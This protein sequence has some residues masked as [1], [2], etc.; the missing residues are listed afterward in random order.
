MSPLCRKPGSL[1][2]LCS[3]CPREG[4]VP[5][6]QQSQHWLPGQG[7]QSLRAKLW[8]KRWTLLGGPEG[9]GGRG[10]KLA[11]AGGG[12]TPH[13][14]GHTGA[15]DLP[16]PVDG[17]LPGQPE[18]GAAG[19]GSRAGGLLPAAQCGTPPHRSPEAPRSNLYM[20]SPHTRG[21]DVSSHREAMPFCF[22]LAGEGL[23]SSGL[24]GA[25]LP[26]T[27]FPEPPTVGHVTRVLL[28]GPR[29]R[30]P[31]CHIPFAKSP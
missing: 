6:A 21:T 7:A 12:E 22:I 1:W 18:P 17:P 23:Q 20:V 30:G 24:R 13:S 16:L 29:R 3:Q 27:R 14:H 15:E 31:S 4:W 19:A 10:R 26:R 2:P 5:A 28:A 8:G 11:S 9:L 25:A